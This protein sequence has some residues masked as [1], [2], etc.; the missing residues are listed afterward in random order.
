MTTTSSVFDELRESLQSGGVEACLARLV[1]QLEAQKKHQELFEARKMQARSELGLPLL[2]NELPESLSDDERRQLEDKLIDAY[3]TIYRD[4]GLSMFRNRELGQG[5]T[6]LQAA[7]EEEAAAR[8]LE[9]M[10]VDEDVLDEFVDVALNQGAA[11]TLGFAAVLEHYGTCNA[12]TTYEQVMYGRPL[13]VRQSAAAMLVDHLHEELLAT[14]KADIAQQEGSEPAAT[15]LRELVAGRDW[16]FSQGAYH[17]DTT[18]LASTVRFAR[19]LEDE[20]NLRTAIDLTEYGR[21][22]EEPFQ[23]EGEEP[24]KEIYPSHALYFH[25]LL[26]EQVDEALEYFRSRAQEV[27][28]AEQGTAAAE[29]YIALLDRT[30][31]HAEAAQATIELIP[32]GVHTFGLA[33]SLFELCE[34]AGDFE[35]LI[36]A[37]KERDE[38]LGFAAGLIHSQL[39][40]TS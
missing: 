28:P 5:W 29:V 13:S 35:P 6:L 23:Y 30:G 38:L 2:S 22:L 34:R 36:S 3:R 25:A 17:I 18:H 39:S 21:R 4:V 7:G 33:P 10:E 37:C 19:V 15:A 24:F 20:P 16:L 11:A 32:P 14:L 40:S 12:I 27:D 26:G 9:T 8:E 1:E 31:R